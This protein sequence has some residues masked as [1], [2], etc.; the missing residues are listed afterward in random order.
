MINAV[1]STEDRHFFSEGALNPVSIARAFIADVRGTGDLQGASTITQQ[2][3]KQTYLSS[4]RSLTRKIKEA[5]L[6]IR[7][8]SSES[9]R[10]ILQNY[11]NTIYW[12]R[13]AYGVEAAAAGLLRQEREPAGPARGVPAGRPDPGADDR[14][15]GPRSRAG[16]GQPD[17]HPEGD[18]AR[19]EDH[20]GRGHPR[21]GSPFLL[22]RDHAIQQ[23]APVAPASGRRR[24]LHLRRP[25]G[26]DRQVRGADGRRGR[27]PGHHH[28]RS[29]L[30]GRGLQLRSTARIRTP[31]TRPPASP[32]ARWCRSATAGS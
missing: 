12:G 22:L 18:G 21:R 5:A 6:A 2:Y 30:A 28:A 25:P 31:S 32:P 8:A 10:E 24:L 1:V 9:K 13:G 15:P 19:Q 4:Q 16:P 14:R 27:A 7:L 3:V 29:H 23:P 20:R 26:A 17:R 11:L